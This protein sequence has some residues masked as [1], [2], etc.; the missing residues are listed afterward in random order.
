ML[1]QMLSSD[2]LSHCTLSAI[3]VQLLGVVDQSPTF[4]RFS[5]VLK[6]HLETNEYTK[7]LRRLKAGH[8]RFLELKKDRNFL[9][10]L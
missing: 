9:K 5:E 2:R 3:S 4:P 7:F 1:M 6:Y 10:K 8:L